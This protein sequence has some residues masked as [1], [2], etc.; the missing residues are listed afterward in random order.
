MIIRIHALRRMF[1]RGISELDIR[2]VLA[3]GEVIEDRPND[4]PFSTALILGRVSGR[5]IH[6]VVAIDSESNTDI[7]VTVYEPDL[8]RWL[9]GF[10]QR[11]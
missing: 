8:E 6:V 3:H 1:E 11:R 10:R 9:T 5:P 4:H 7:I 2:E